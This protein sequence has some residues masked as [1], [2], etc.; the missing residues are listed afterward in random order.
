MDP[1]KVYKALTDVNTTMAAGFKDMHLKIDSKFNNC[2]KRLGRVE[3]IIAV[4][5]AICEKEEKKKDFWK[6]IVRAVTVAGIIALFGIVWKLVL[7]SSTL[8]G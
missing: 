4:K 2:D 1:E 7:F 5:K 3:T 6:W 8:P